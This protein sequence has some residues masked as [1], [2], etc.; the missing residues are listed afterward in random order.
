MQGGVARR[1]APRRRLAVDA[2]ILNR[3]AAAE[4]PVVRHLKGRQISIPELVCC[5]S[6][7]EN[8]QEDFRRESLTSAVPFARA[9]LKDQALI[10]GARRRLWTAAMLC[11][12][13]RVPSSRPA[14]TQLI[15]WLA[16]AVSNEGGSSPLMGPAP[17]VSCERGRD[18]RDQ[19]GLM[20]RGGGAGR[21]Y[22]GEIGGCNLTA[23][24]H[25]NPRPA[26]G[27]DNL[28]ACTGADDLR[29]DCELASHRPDLQAVGP[30]PPCLSR[31]VRPCD[32][33]LSA[34]RFAPRP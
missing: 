17:A 8:P 21:K 6:S 28:A 30:A 15:L 23:D 32:T 12:V 4:R 31:S 18:R 14:R 13:Q 25:P 2:L 24:P 26:A 16:S 19:L 33:R 10:S 1:L 29:L 9:S 7:R 27:E 3:D 34:G 22:Q 20:S 5:R 11:V